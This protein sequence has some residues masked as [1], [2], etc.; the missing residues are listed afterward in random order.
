MRS[1]Q[2]IPPTKGGFI[3][4]TLTS[5][6]KEL[7]ISAIFLHSIVGDVVLHIVFG[8]P[9]PSLNDSNSKS[10]LLISLTTIW[11]EDILKTPIAELIKFPLPAAG[12]HSFSFSLHSPLMLLASS[13][14]SIPSSRSVGTSP[15]CSCPLETIWCNTPA[16]ESAFIF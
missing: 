1:T 14:T 8:K 5:A 9:K 16:T 7:S 3:T 10:L 6:K 2:Y 13:A 12:S 11:L 4:T 15:L